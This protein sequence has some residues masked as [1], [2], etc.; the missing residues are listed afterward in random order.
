MMLNIIFEIGEYHGKRESQQF[1]KGEEILGRGGLVKGDRLLNEP[2]TGVC[3]HK[4]S[5]DRLFPLLA[6]SIETQVSTSFQPSG[7]FNIPAEY[8]PKKDR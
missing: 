6:N 1:S 7:F 3:S 2:L 4:P 8:M 5:Q